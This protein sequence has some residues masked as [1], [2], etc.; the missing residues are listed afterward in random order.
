[1]K[2]WPCRKGHFAS[3][4]FKGTCFSNLGGTFYLRWVLFSSLLCSHSC[5]FLMWG[6][7]TGPHEKGQPFLG[8]SKKADVFT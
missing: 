8:E 2:P 5:I 3:S 7:L 4:F 6:V 1:M